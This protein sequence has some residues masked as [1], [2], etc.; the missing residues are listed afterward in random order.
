MSLIIESFL[1]GCG[2]GALIVIASP[3]FVAARKER[4]NNRDAKV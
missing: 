2:I 4:E 3:L 1:M